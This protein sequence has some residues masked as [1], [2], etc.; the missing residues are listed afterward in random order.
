[1]AAQSN[2]QSLLQ[3]L[4]GVHTAGQAFVPSSVNNGNPNTAY[5]QPK[6][7]QLPVSDGFI[8]P[9]TNGFG[10]WQMPAVQ[11]PTA[12]ASK[13]QGP[14]WQALAAKAPTN[15]VP[16]GFKGFPNVLAGAGVGWKPG[17]TGIGTP[18]TPPV[19]PPTTGGTNTGGNLPPQQGTGTFNPKFTNPNDPILNGGLTNGRG[20]QLL[21]LPTG[22]TSSLYSN[23]KTSGSVSGSDFANAFKGLGDMNVNLGSAGV[24]LAGTSL[25]RALGITANGTINVAQIADFFIPGNIY[26]SQTNQFNWANAIPALANAINPMLGFAVTKVMNYF[27]QKYANEDD[28]K[29]G[30][31]VMGALRRML[32]NRYL[33]NQANKAAGR[34]GGNAHAG[35]GG[36]NS[37]GGGGS[38]F[39]FGGGWLETGNTTGGTQ[40]GYNFD[41][42]GGAHQIT[43]G[44][45][46]N[47]I[48][49]APVDVSKG[50]YFTGGN[51]FG[52]GVGGEGN[53]GFGGYGGYGG[54]GASGGTS[55][56]TG[57]APGTNGQSGSGA[58]SG[59]I[60]GLPIKQE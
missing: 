19:T 24:A 20:L 25:G 51:T 44:T 21:D 1:M 59:S 32:K 54:F 57:W 9:A 49:G 38:P 46:V 50:G 3:D 35:G 5:N 10:N 2:I 11:V 22:Y 15:Q 45:W 42:G 23:T 28:S 52:G 31:G 4:S 7:Y 12:P 13:F 36:N 17:T 30:T 43:D 53:G 60:S 6:V 47:D 55:R 16:G 39:D 34:N 18:V 40:Y 26:M 14:D 56:G 58:G 41:P 8:P 48:T 37:I 33:K 29:L 27:G